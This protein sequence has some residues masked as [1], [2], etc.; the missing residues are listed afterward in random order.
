MMPE[1]S[2]EDK[3]GV[4]LAHNERVCQAIGALSPMQMGTYLFLLQFCT[5]P[6]PISQVLA[7]VPH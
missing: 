5:D 1:V 6:Q 7:A 4:I 3:T 2:M